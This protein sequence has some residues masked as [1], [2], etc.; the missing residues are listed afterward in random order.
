MW[1]DI[2]GLRICEIFELRTRKGICYCSTILL[3]TRQKL[4][5]IYWTNSL[6]YFYHII[7]LQTLPSTTHISFDCSESPSKLKSHYDCH[8]SLSINYEQ[9]ITSPT[10]EKFHFFFLK[11]TSWRLYTKLLNTNSNL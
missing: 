5:W 11:I 10:Y 6:I 3:S 4:L 1:I 7:N 2:C 8:S 9:N